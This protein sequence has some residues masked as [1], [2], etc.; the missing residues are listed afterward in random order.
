MLTHFLLGLYAPREGQAYRERQRRQGS[1][2]DRGTP[3]AE[4]ERNFGLV[5]GQVRSIRTPTQPS[6]YNVYDNDNL[7][8]N[9]SGLDFN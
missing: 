3:G 9:I 1:Q 6:S 7:G 4:F 5:D 8:L 2:F